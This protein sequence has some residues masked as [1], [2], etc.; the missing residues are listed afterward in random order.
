MVSAIVVSH[1]SERDLGQ[2][3]ESLRD[4]T[5]PALELLVVDNASFDRSVQIAREAGAQVLGLPRNLGFS[6]ANNAGV[7]RCNG[8]YVLF[9]NPDARLE[10]DFVALLVDALQTD[11]QAASAYGKLLKGPEGP[12]DS[13]GI[14][15]GRA[16]LQPTDR[17][18]G[19]PD[20]GQYD[21]PRLRDEPLGPSAAAA[22]YR[23]AALD[24]LAPDGEVFDEDFFA[25]YEDVDLAWRA[26]NAG[27][28]CL[29]EPRARGEHPR[30]GPR[31][32][33][34]QIRRRADLNRL[35]LFLK[36]ERYT[37]IE[38][39]TVLP[40]QLIWETLRTLSRAV[41]DPGYLRFLISGLGLLPRMLRKRRS[42]RR[43]ER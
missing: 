18:E 38:L 10:P 11:P 36:N 37:W 27:W 21:T 29:Y 15:L 28:R 5:W 1:N 42:I 43:R 26:R 40:R 14:V 16:R 30:S 4:Q 13:T 25:Y 34:T 24:E 17:G 22:I 6:V 7:A 3:L 2:C 19:E 23:R 33:G 12:L 39:I 8:E 41:D 20:R 9:I 32:H 35:W 31:A